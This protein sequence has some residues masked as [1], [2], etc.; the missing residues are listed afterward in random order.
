MDQFSTLR[1]E[2]Q[3]CPAQDQAV[4]EKLERGMEQFGLH[5]DWEQMAR[6]SGALKRHRGI[7][8]ARDLF[9][10]VLGYS[11]LDYSLRQLGIW[12]T[13]LDLAAVSKTALLNRLRHCRKW[14]GQLLVLVLHQ[15]HL[16]FP[17]GDPVRVKLLDA[18][19]ICRPGS[20]GRIGACISASIWPLL[21]WIRSSSPTGEAPSGWI[22][23]SW[24]PGRLASATRPMPWPGL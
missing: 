19:V 3:I 21:A 23:L 13:T 14:L 7:H 24:G 1:N 17:A 5:L 6:A 10:L 20:R 12:G 8:S 16:R 9:R 4:R 22:G 2:N 18:T 15:Q 11:V